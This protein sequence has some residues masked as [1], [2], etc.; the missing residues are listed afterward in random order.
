MTNADQ[1]SINSIGP[2]GYLA[3]SARIGVVTRKTRRTAKLPRYRSDRR[4]R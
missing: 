4:S 2:S 1:I 3:D